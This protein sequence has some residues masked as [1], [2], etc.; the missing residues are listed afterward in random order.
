MSKEISKLTKVTLE[1]SK[2]IQKV[3]NSIKEKSEKDLPFMEVKRK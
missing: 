2:K 1:A 3:L